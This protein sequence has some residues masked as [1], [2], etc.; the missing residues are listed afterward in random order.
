[1]FDFIDDIEKFW[2]GQ[3]PPQIGEICFTLYTAKI[4]EDVEISVDI[5]PETVDSSQVNDDEMVADFQA[6]SD[7]GAKYQVNVPTEALEDGQFSN[8]SVLGLPYTLDIVCVSSPAYEKGVVFD[9]QS[10]RDYIAD[11]IEALK[12]NMKSQTI[13]SIIKSKPLFETYPLLKITD[14]EYALTN[15][16]LNLVALIKLQE[17][18][19]TKSEYGTSNANTLANKQNASPT[20][21]G[22][23]S[24]TD[25]DSNTAKD[26]GL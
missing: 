14:F 20:Q 5:A 10:R 3:P 15:N 11:I 6:L 12:Q 16:E 9:D 17:V 19:T 23:V 22:R 1:M 4:F 26:I 24:P 8:D 18:R 2:N 25:I 21:N 13:V 7:F